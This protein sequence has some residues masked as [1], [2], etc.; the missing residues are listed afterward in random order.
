MKKNKFY[1]KIHWSN[2]D[3]TE[4][5][6]DTLD[7]RD[8]L[9]KL[10]TDSTSISISIGTGGIGEFVIPKGHIRMIEFMDEQ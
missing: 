4:I 6:Y 5:S 3:N 1:A 7:K 9:K 10:F 2:G 8:G